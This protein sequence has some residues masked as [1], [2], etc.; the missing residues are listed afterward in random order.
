MKIKYLI[1]LQ[2]FNKI[3]VNSTS[4]QKENRKTKRIAKTEEKKGTE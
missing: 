3:N 2:R 1:K 4:R